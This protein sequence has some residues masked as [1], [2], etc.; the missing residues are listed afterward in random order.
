MSAHENK[1]LISFECKHNSLFSFYQ[2]EMDKDK[3]IDM[4]DALLKIVQHADAN[5]KPL[6]LDIGDRSGTTDYIDFIRPNEMKSCIMFGT[7]NFQRSFVSFLLHFE[8]IIQPNLRNEANDDR[9]AFDNVITLFKRYTNA[10]RWT[11]AISHGT[12]ERPEISESATD[13]LEFLVKAAIL[14]SGRNLTLTHHGYE[15]IPVWNVTLKK[16]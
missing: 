2:E 8:P 7:D 9:Q 14:S 11:H 4:Q 13:K 16:T 10:E 5:L 15:Y 6:N 1:D 12:E 3:L